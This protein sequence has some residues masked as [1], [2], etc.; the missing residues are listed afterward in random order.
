[1]VAE[2]ARRS[3]S[4]RTPAAYRGPPHHGGNRRRR[5]DQ[6]RVLF[7]DEPTA[8]LTVKE[9]ET[10]SP[11]SDAC[12]TAGVGIVRQPPPRRNSRGLRPRDH[13][14]RRRDHRNKARLEL[15]MDHI[16]ATM[17]GR[18][19]ETVHAKRAVPIGKSRKVHRLTARDGSFRDITFDVRATRSS[20]S[21]ASSGRAQRVRPGC[22]ASAT[23]PRAPSKSTAS[24]FA[25]VPP[26]TPWPRASPIPRRTASYRPFCASTPS[27]P[28]PA[29]RSCPDSAPALLS[30]AAANSTWRIA[31]FAK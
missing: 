6:S 25:S 14:A 11:R 2:M 10:S 17:V 13:H 16:V 29:S 8:S 27:G 30:A 7:L 15:T 3:T 22:S 4:H 26:A 12:A 9:I 31:S 24:P 18:E 21:T 19:L 23:P 28:T 1:M 5:S 20:A